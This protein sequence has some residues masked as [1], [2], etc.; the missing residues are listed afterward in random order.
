MPQARALGGAFD[1]SG[2]VGHHE[3]AALADA[4]HAQMRMQRGKRI[5]RHLGTRIRHGAQQSRLAGIGHAEQTDVGEHLQLERERTAL[6]GLARRRAP[7]AAIGAR[8]EMGVPETALA[9]V[10][11]EQRFAVAG[12]F[13][14]QLFGFRIRHAR[15]EGNLDIK[16]LAGFSGAVAP[17]ALGAVLAAE[18]ACVTEIDERI[19]SLLPDR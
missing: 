19:E 8:L 9:A 16:I 3:T 15:A 13:A 11:H 7:R 17:A 2:N 5:V 12:D 1:E 6:A 4:H 14:D 18:D 10:G